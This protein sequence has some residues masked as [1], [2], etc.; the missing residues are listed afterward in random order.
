MIFYYCQIKIPNIQVVDIAFYISR[1]D[2][3]NGQ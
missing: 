3:Q 2:A 1:V